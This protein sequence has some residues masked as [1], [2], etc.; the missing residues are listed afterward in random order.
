MPLTERVV[1]TMEKKLLDIKRTPYE[2]EQKN[3]AMDG[4]CANCSNG[5]CN[6]GGGGTPCGGGGGH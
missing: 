6:G 5:N 1:I 4:K 3:C 2:A